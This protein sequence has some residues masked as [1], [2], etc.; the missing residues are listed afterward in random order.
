MKTTTMMIQSLT[1]YPTIEAAYEA[2][3]GIRGLEDCAAARALSPQNAVVV[4]FDQ[5]DNGVDG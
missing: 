3:P 5:K 1:E 4:G 2:L